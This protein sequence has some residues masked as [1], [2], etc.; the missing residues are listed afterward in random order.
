M[1]DRSICVAYAGKPL[2]AHQTCYWKVRVWNREGT[3]S[4]WSESGFGTMGYLPAPSGWKPK[5]IGSE[6]R[7]PLLRQEFKV[8][9]LTW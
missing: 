2:A 9:K 3:E 5:W 7:T 6:G 4:A 1:S 8:A